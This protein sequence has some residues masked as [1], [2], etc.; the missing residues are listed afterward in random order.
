VTKPEPEDEREPR[1][2][3]DWLAGFVRDSGL[4]PVLVVALG[5]LAAIG[6]GALLLAIRGRSLPAIAALAHER[7][8][9]G[10]YHRRL[11]SSAVPMA[12]RLL[13]AADVY[14]AMTEV[15]PHRP[16]L[17]PAQAAAELRRE[18]SAGRLD[19][20]AVDAV[21]GAAGHQV[22]P[23]RAPYPAGLSEREVQVLR[24][25]ARGR[26]NKEIAAHL[27]ISVKTT[28]N[29]VQHTFEKIGVTTRAAAALFA[30]QNDLLPPPI[31]WR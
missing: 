8:D 13:A 17:A 27:D 14:H 15:R 21:L 28:G 30:M 3:D 19:C 22:A 9:G 2:L 25:L 23:T 31:P 10:G 5:C 24:V 7:L 1:N 16:A 29:H 26:T 18:A 12:A 20:D 6:A 11:P 4:R